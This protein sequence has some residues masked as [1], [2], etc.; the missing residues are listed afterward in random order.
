MV[1]RPNILKLATKISLESMTYTGIT[2]KDPEYRI[3]APIVDDD[4]CDVMM[5]MRLEA[6]RTA[7]E[8]ARRCKKDV[9]FVQQQLDKLMVAGVARQREVD[10]QICYYYPI[11]VPGIMEGILANREQC[12]RY[13]DLGAC[14]EEYTRR[15]LEVLVPTLNSGKAG[16]SFMRVM[17]VMSAIEND[18]RTASYDEVATLI[19]NASAIS[20]GPC[21][22]RRARRLMG[23]GCGH[24]E[25][26]MCMYLNENAINYSNTGAH[27]LV[28]KEEAYEILRRAEDNGLVHEINQTPGFEDATAICNCCG[29]S[30]FALRIA[31]MFRSKNA[32]RSNFVARV[33]KEKCVACGQCVEN[34]QTNALRLGQKRCINDPTIANAYD[35]DRAI[36]WDKK[37]YNIDYRTNRSDVMESGTAPCKAVC[38]AHIPVQGY[39]K[40]ASEGRYTEA[41][42]LIKKENPFPAVCGRICNKVCEEACSRGIVDASVAI[43]DIKKFIAEKDLS[44]ETRFVPKMLNQTGRPYEEKIAVIGAGPAGLSCAYYL[45]VKGYPVTVFEKEQMLGG[46][47]T[48]GIPS[49][50]LDRAVVNAEI[51]VLRELGVQFRTGVAVGKDVTLDQLRSEGFKAFYLGIGASKGAGLGC[52]GEELGGV[53]TG[54]DFLRRVNQGEKPELGSDVAVIGGGNVAIDV[55]RSA[56]R[57]GAENVTIIYRRGRDEMPAADDEIA[58]AEEEGVKFRFL[59]SPVEILGDGKCEGLKLERMELGE[60][61]ARGRRK[62][63]GTGRFETV[64]VTAVISAIGQKIDLSGIAD[65][66]TDKSGSVLVSLPSYQTSVADVFAGGDVVTGPKF[67]IDAIAAGKEGAVSIHRFV[68]PGQTQNLGRDNRDY[69]ALDASTIAISVGSFDTAPRQKAASGSAAEARKTF[70]DLRGTLTEEQIRKEASRCLGCGCVVIDEDLC[71]GCGICTTKCKFD[72]I[73]LEKTI[74]NKGKTY[75]RTLMTAASQAPLAVGRLARKKLGKK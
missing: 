27:R 73:R 38:P 36:P 21:S 53:S 13:P 33:D 43:D 72:A 75:Y 16:M 56:L 39:I 28:S 2:Y 70:K 40:L 35:S 26:D 71:V 31:E 3:L 4:M 29:C 45:A 54:I 48:M 62:A 10:G 67:A 52:P 58:E 69:K 34:C 30:C 63:V 12:D 57:L 49:F 15:R 32:I 1:N 60:S 9:A 74:D 18:S 55:A 22:C 61:D 46:M 44:A 37:S 51:D 41:L 5:H 19:E 24:L 20:V 59:A 14:F 47:L 23:E 8:L 11:W 50:R 42:E 65:F 66:E 17:P 25:E 64:P 7:E 6:N 68:H